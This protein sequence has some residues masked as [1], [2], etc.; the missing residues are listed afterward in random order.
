ME[1]L[2]ERRLNAVRNGMVRKSRQEQ[3]KNV[4]NWKKKIS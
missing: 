1:K 3:Q 2:K 4:K